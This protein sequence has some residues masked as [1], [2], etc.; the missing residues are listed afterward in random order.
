MT[1]ETGVAPAEAAGLLRAKLG[2]M[3][4][5]QDNAAAGARPSTSVETVL[6]I[7]VKVEII[8]GS[9]LMPVARLMD[10]S[11]GM[12]IPL[13]QRLGDPVTIAVNGKVIA[14]GEVVILSETE[15]TLA[16]SLTEIVPAAGAAAAS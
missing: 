11:R 12:T 4:R 9:T 15:G 10:L 7:P 5:S 8:L 16:V 2:E 6:G 1:V 14:R 3:Q 13:D